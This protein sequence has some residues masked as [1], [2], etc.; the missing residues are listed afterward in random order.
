MGFEAYDVSV[1][2]G[3]LARMTDGVELEIRPLSRQTF[4]YTGP[5]SSRAH[6]ARIYNGS[7]K[8]L[9]FIEG[10]EGVFVPVEI[11]GIRGYV[12]LDEVQIERLDTQ[13]FVI[14]PKPVPVQ[15]AVEEKPKRQRKAKTVNVDPAEPVQL[16]LPLNTEE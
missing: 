15:E 9:V 3:I 5:A 14:L 7:E 4:V 2:G 10:R 16:E 8:G 1:A 11:Q 13:R 6:I 12:R